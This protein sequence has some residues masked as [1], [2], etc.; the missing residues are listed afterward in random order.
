MPP[1]SALTLQRVPPRI[2][3]ETMT[4][5]SSVILGTGFV[6]LLAAGLALEHADP[7]LAW[8]GIAALQTVAAVLFARSALLAGSE[9][10][11]PSWAGG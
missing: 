10:P 3:A 8:I 11:V 4:V 2:C 9:G 7:S 1:I 5:A 6:A